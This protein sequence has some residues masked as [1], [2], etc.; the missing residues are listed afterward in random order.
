M[1]RVTHAKEYQRHHHHAKAPCTRLLDYFLLLFGYTLEDSLAKSFWHKCLGIY[2]KKID[3]N[4][5]Y[6]SVDDEKRRLIPPLRLRRYRNLRLDSLGVAPSTRLKQERERGTI[7]HGANAI[8]ILRFCT[9]SDTHL[10]SLPA[11]SEHQVDR[12]A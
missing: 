11:I 1:G 10:G 8:F 2:R 7:E 5:N 12:V 4:V 6:A 3:P 9:R